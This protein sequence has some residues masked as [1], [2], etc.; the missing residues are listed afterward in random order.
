M[1]RIGD[2]MLW[3]TYYENQEH[4][5]NQYLSPQWI[6]DSGLAPEML[7]TGA[8]TLIK[9]MEGQPKPLIKAKVFDYILRNGRIDVDPVDWFQDRIEHRDIIR[10]LRQIWWRYVDDTYMA[11][12]HA[13]ERTAWSLGAFYSGADFSHT[14]P[15]WNSLLELGI[16]GLLKRIRYKRN[17]RLNIEKL[18]EEETVFYEAS[19]IVYQAVIAFFRRLA[20][21]SE[22][23]AETN[24]DNRER[25]LICAQSLK[26]L[27]VRP[28]ETMHEALQLGI[29]FYELQEMEGEYVRSHGGFDRLYYRFYENDIKYNRY[30]LEQ[31]RELIRFF[32]TKLNANRFYAGRPFYL[33]GILPNGEDAVNPL[34]Y[35]ALDIYNELGLPYIKIHIRVHSGTSDYFLEKALD[36]IRG[37]NN[38]IV[39]MHDETVI[40]ALMGTGI[41][42]TEAREYTP[43]GCYE[44]AVMGLEVP[45]TFNSF[46]NTAKAVEL[47]LHGGTDPLTGIRLANLP[48][49]SDYPSF[50]VFYDAVKKQL[51]SMVKT[52]MDIVLGY[53]KHYIEINPSP[54]FSGTLADCVDRGR[55][56]YAG[57]ARYNNSSIVFGGLGSAVDSLIAIRK[58]VFENQELSLSELIDSL[59]NNWEGNELLRMKI[60]NDPDKW[61]NNRAESDLIAQDFMN[62]ASKLVINKP[63]NRGGVFKTGLFTI[64]HHMYCGS[65]MGAMPDGRKAKAPLSKNLSSVISM[66]RQ[67][68]T[69]LISSAAKI[70]FTQ[71]PDGTVLDIMLHPSAVQ[72]KDGLNAMLDLVKTFFKEGGFSLQYNVLDVNTLKKAQENP[73]EYANL[74]VRVCGWNAY[75]IDLSKPLQDEFIHQAENA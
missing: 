30:T 26:N 71:F 5:N 43:I 47:T 63:N 64:D 49:G 55:D 65:K 62:F 29:I 68:V 42:L 46:I 37:G 57:G 70:D 20:K 7:E 69:A 52:A 9:N 66:D 35:D 60:Y 3:N 74:Q 75:F 53:E 48:Q 39:F 8:N 23:M 1:N 14:S 27:A 58:F 72:G 61:G 17:S 19:E 15:D 2:L 54:L 40:T 41:S 51:E 59:K 16:P 50:E 6:E 32:Y 25:L 11:E 18:T 38:S 34:T 56:A 4:L 44:T 73:E 12:I 33:G 24:P 31:E 45:C 36:Y 13:Y 28:P 21:Q 22:K 67:G 10:N